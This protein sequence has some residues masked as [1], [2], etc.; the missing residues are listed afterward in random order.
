MSK[1]EPR[2]REEAFAFQIED[3]VRVLRACALNSKESFVKALDRIKRELVFMR[4]LLKQKTNDNL[5]NYS[6]NSGFVFVSPHDYR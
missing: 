3:D 2:N 1:S 4:K 5:G 6:H